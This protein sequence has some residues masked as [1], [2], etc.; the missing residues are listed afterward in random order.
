MSFDAST[1]VS[2]NISSL[3][4]NDDDII[5]NTNQDNVSNTIATY[6]T[7]KQKGKNPGERP[8][9]EV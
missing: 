2:E 9:S 6:I 4:D 5:S 1:K 7:R 3:S 8:R